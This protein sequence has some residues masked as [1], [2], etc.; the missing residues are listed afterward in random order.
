M[1]LKEARAYDVG[2]VDALL[3]YMRKREKLAAFLE[4]VSEHP[5]TPESLEQNG[6]IHLDGRNRQLPI[7]M[8]H[9]I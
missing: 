9:R 4:S 2:G 8:S 5:G 6:A 1:F 3:A 7:R